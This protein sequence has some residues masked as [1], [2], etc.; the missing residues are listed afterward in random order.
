MFSSIAGLKPLPQNYV[1]ESLYNSLWD[2]LNDTLHAF[3]SL[4]LQDAIMAHCSTALEMPRQR[5]GHGKRPG[6]LATEKG[7]ATADEPKPWGCLIEILHCYWEELD[8]NLVPRIVM[9]K[10]FRA[11]FM[12]INAQLLNGVCFTSARGYCDFSSLNNLSSGITKIVEW[13]KSRPSMEKSGVYNAR[14]ELEPLRQALQLMKLEDKQNV[15]V[16]TI[17]AKCPRLSAGQKRIIC[18]KYKDDVAES[19][20]FSPSVCEQLKQREGGTAHDMLSVEEKV[21]VPTWREFAAEQDLEALKKAMEPGEDDLCK[22]L[23][24]S[25][26]FEFL[27]QPLGRGR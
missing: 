18:S 19:P 20:G 12:L 15:K 4:V 26:R 8:V 16:S 9:E 7:A 24:D 22:P 6:T 23:R 17:D 14:E 21:E 10:F 5:K 25:E 13:T 1:V 2:Q 11:V 27:K 3:M